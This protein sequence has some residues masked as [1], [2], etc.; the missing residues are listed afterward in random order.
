MKPKFLIAAVAPLL[1]INASAFPLVTNFTYSVGQ[2]VPD[3][4][5]NGF[6]NSQVISGVD[7]IIDS[8]TVQINLSG[9]YNGD[10]YM[11]LTHIS[12]FSV[13]LNRPGVTTTDGFGYSD[14]GFN[15]TF[16]DLAAQDI[17]NYGGN[18][19]LPLT[20]TW[21]VDGRNWDPATV[22]DTT[23]RTAFLSSF[24]NLDPN[25][26]WTLFI[27]DMSGGGGLTTLNTWG[28]TITTVP[29][30]STV[31]LVGLFGGVFALVGGRRWWRNRRQG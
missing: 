4:N 28:L 30:P 14:S 1:A 16:D 23:A 8:I 9:G 26:P 25:G 22:L 29:E 27:A 6:A 19:G 13:L 3:G 21:Q 5:P 18:G 31:A 10:L 15:I 20:G 12:G 11:Y 17:H 2:T 24:A 7:G